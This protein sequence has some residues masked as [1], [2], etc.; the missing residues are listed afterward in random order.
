M[1]INCQNLHARGLRYGL[2]WCEIQLVL[3]TEEKHDGQLCRFAVRMYWSIKLGGAVLPIIRDIERD[4]T[5]FLGKNE[6]MRVT[7]SQI[8]NP[9]SRH[10]Q[11]RDLFKA[12]VRRT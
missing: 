2:F 5:L 10:I 6:S 9:I 4:R 12:N 7:S 3:A 11:K 8:A 1:L